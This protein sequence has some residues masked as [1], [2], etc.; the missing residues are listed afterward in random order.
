MSPVEAAATIRDAI[1][2]DPDL[3][4]ALETMVARSEHADIYEWCDAN[5]AEAIAIAQQALD[6]EGQIAN[7]NTRLSQ[8]DLS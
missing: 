2:T 4:R 8:G 6:I 5:S 1:K 3:R 7:M